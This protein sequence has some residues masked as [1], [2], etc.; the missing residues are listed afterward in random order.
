MS[1]FTKHQNERRDGDDTKHISRRDVL[2]TG[3]GLAGA[4]IF[5]GRASGQESQTSPQLDLTRPLPTKA[6]GS[7]GNDAPLRQIDIERRALRPDDVLLDVLYSGVCH[8]DIHTARGD[9]GPASR[10]CV[11]GHE[12][13]GR[14]IAVGDQVTK[15]KVG[16]IGGV[17]CMVNSCRECDHCRDDREQNCENGVTFTYGSDDSVSGGH[18]YGGYSDKMVVTEHFVIRI[19]P[20]ADLAAT[21][22]LLCAGITTFSPMQHWQL[23]ADQR[24]GVVGLGGL[25]HLAVKLAAAR[26]A[27]VTVFTTSPSKVADAKEMGAEEAVVSTDTQAMQAHA[28]KYDLL[29]VTIPVAYAVQPYLSLLKLDGTLVNVGEMGALEQVMGGS[30]VF[31]RKSVAGSLIGGI[32]ETQEVVDYCAARGIKADIEMIP[33]QEINKAWD[34]VVNK[35]VRYRYVIDMASMKAS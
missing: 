11:P 7:D 21:A 24:V 3:A 23:K 20:G 2:A 12:I 15:F 1:D 28:G 19:P 33:I 34:S 32:A 26:G 35:E 8:S 17:G 14:V 4:S 29:I 16:D 27:K 22:P 30:L 13:I 6:Y 18:T 25:G 5:A 31:G 9:W 10:P